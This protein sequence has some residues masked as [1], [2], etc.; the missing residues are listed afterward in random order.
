MPHRVL[1]LS[2]VFFSNSR[3]EIKFKKN[4]SQ[5]NQHMLINSANNSRTRNHEKPDQNQ[6]KLQKAAAQDPG[7]GLPQYAPKAK[8]REKANDTDYVFIPS[9]GKIEDL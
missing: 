3:S 9:D 6:Q 2:N 1:T 7:L 4:R 8:P 5:A